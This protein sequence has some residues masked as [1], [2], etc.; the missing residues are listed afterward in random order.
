MKKV[1]ALLLFIGFVAV[2][3][4]AQRSLFYTSILKDP[5]LDYFDKVR[6]VDSIIASDTIYW[7]DSTLG[8]K[9]YVRWK[10]EMFPR[11]NGDGKLEDFTSSLQ[12][13]FDDQNPP[14]TVP[15]TL[16]PGA[17]SVALTASQ[18]WANWKTIG[19][20]EMVK[21][22]DENGNYTKQALGK[23]DRVW[24]YNTEIIYAASDKGGL[25]KTEDGG[26]TWKSVPITINKQGGGR[27]F[28]PVIGVRALLVHPNDPD[29]V[30]VST[31]YGENQGL[32]TFKTDDGGENW[33]L[34][35]LVD[36]SEDPAR[37]NMWKMVMDP[38]NPDHIYAITQNKLLE[39]TNGGGVLT[40]G[41]G[42]QVNTDWVEVPGSAGEFVDEVL[43][44]LEV[45]STGDVVYVAGKSI[46]EVD[47][48][49]GTVPVDL[50]SRAGTFMTTGATTHLFELPDFW[51]GGY[52]PNGCSFWDPFANY[53]HG[54][55]TTI[56]DVNDPNYNND[57]LRICDQVNQ[58]LATGVLLKK[59]MTREI[60]AEESNTVFPNHELYRR[61]KD[62]VEI[63]LMLKHLEVPP[64]TRLVVELT[65][66]T[67]GPNIKLFDSDFPSFTIDPT[68]FLVSYNGQKVWTLTA[69]YDRL[70]LKASANGSFNEFDILKLVEL[71]IFTSTLVELANEDW[72]GARIDIDQ[73]DNLYGWVHAGPT[74]TNSFIV[75][76]VGATGLS[77][78]D[79]INGSDGRVARG[80]HDAFEV[81]KSP[82]DGKG[83]ELYTGSVDLW[84]YRID[85]SDLNN[86][87]STYSA[88]YTNDGVLHVDYRDL[89]T[90]DL[91]DHVYVAHDGGL[92][93]INDNES[94]NGDPTFSFTDYSSITGKGL[95][96]GHFWSIDFER[97]GPLTF[98]GGG[99][100][101]QGAYYK[102]SSS[103]EWRN[104]TN[105]GGD[106]GDGG[107]LEIHNDWDGD[108][109]KESLI[110]FFP[111]GN[112]NAEIVFD[113]NNGYES[114]LGGPKLKQPTP[115]I[116]ST[117]HVIEQASDGQY[118]ACFSNVLYR[119][120]I[121]TSNWDIEKTFDNS[122]DA[123]VIQSIAIAPSD[124]DI[125]YV[126]IKE[127]RYGDALLGER[128]WRR[129]RQNGSL[130]WEAIPE[131]QFTGNPMGNQSVGDI[132]VSHLD[133]NKV[134]V[135]F[136][137]FHQDNNRVFYSDNAA[138][139]LSSVQFDDIVPGGQLPSFPASQ[140][141]TLPY[142]DDAVFVGTD[143]GLFIGCK[144]GSNWN[145]E[146][147]SK[148]EANLDWAIP[149]VHSNLPLGR[150]ADIYVDKDDNKVFA[151]VFG[152]GIWESHVP[153]SEPTADVYIGTTTWNGSI[154]QVNYD[155]IV[156]AGETF[157]LN[158]CQL[159]FG[160]ERRIIVENGGQLV[161]NNS[162]LTNA[163]AEEWGGILV[164]GPGNG[165]DQSNA[166]RVQISNST[167][168]NAEY[169]VR[170]GENANNS[171]GILIATTSTF[172]NC[173]Y[174]VYYN[175]YA[176]Q[177]MPITG[178]IVNCDF[179]CD[180]PIPGQG[181]LGVK[182]H[183]YLE[184]I[185]GLD[186]LSCS[187]HN[188]MEQ[189]NIA[190]SDKGI[191][192]EAWD[193][194]VNLK[195]S[196]VGSCSNLGD[197]NHFEGLKFGVRLHGNAPL[198][199]FVSNIMDA[200]FKNN[201]HG[202]DLFNQF[203]TILWNN[204]LEWDNEVVPLLSDQNTSCSGVVL[205]HTP[206][207]EFVDNL[208]N[209][210][211]DKFTFIGLKVNESTSLSQ[212][213]L[214]QNNLF[215]SEP[216]ILNNASFTPTDVIAQH[217]TGANDQ[218]YVNCN[219]YLNYLTDWLVDG[220]IALQEG[221]PGLGVDPSN[222]FG[223][224]CSNGI[225]PSGLTFNSINVSP[226]LVGGVDY[227]L[228]P[229]MVPSMCTQGLVN[230]LPSAGAYMGC[231]N[232]VYSIEDI[233][234]PGEPSGGGGGEGQSLPEKSLNIQELPDNAKPDLMVYPNP[235]AGL[236]V[237]SL[238][239]VAGITKINVV[240]LT[241][242]LV[243]TKE[244]NKDLFLHSVNLSQLTNGTY[245]VKVITE[246]QSYAKRIVIH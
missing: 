106:G 217:F 212:N 97:K 223:T 201:E 37:S 35:Y 62:G 202:I 140:V 84:K 22:L 20:E 102:E 18:E 132:A 101:H 122:N 116:P 145:W 38:T 42:S 216:S 182:A 82:Q 28:P 130:V 40:F 11:I 70:T 74:T 222:L 227:V 232:D 7:T 174:G 196:S 17:G 110:N 219:S 81:S 31:C 200:N 171:G 184:G 225:S 85:V 67:G 48:A 47:V 155:I 218:L 10:N 53:W 5:N 124:P 27:Y 50:K 148:Q 78:L 211:T 172:R 142:T 241:G 246:D 150:I 123:M 79:V 19:P 80:F 209:Y 43:Y 175:Q 72:H 61:L 244:V 105:T 193:A 163:C 57:W 89:F 192:I 86:S 158:D 99:I 215:S 204:V 226:T 228:D 51:T 44:D 180:G 52:N 13:N 135:T 240:D 56:T 66:S 8:A 141:A 198:A 126:A 230:F 115:G 207:F 93:R 160:R 220:Q 3:C 104:L 65:S 235:S 71:D 83:I 121:T 164:R 49:A 41:P 131:I 94:F 16:P 199:D 177:T 36:P 108:N 153:C 205:D 92:A 162:T 12:S 68:D 112:S 4:Q 129:T 191:G 233:Y 187:F 98:M 138:G 237:V 69:D 221:E 169:A 168:Q 194:S 39:T 137:H 183:I 179:Y 119:W 151:S 144:S 188:Y 111:G 60:Y 88:K 170:V 152:R 213:S 127:A 206:G 1:T 147:Y 185:R 87:N 6:M 189:D 32:G 195:R 29:I 238:D 139:P 229:F 46:W 186:V 23:M 176:Y 24:P 103:N 59:N 203:G 157:T 167:I 55:H 118:Y 25:F 128:F 156:G 9:Y 45:K 239:G 208:I 133:P 2:T 154:K 107:D 117:K 14:L 90:L 190:N 54:Q 34:Q 242:K 224:P 109:V 114:T 95:T 100:M 91:D 113:N 136:L 197:R 146:R 210:Q 236:F 30:Y 33:T 214:V 143:Y 21:N 234:C 159:A 96:I 231:I 181:G 58:R 75:R 161:I 15:Y 243:Y 165:I 64:N 26:N 149:G 73:Y 173:L 178:S 134:W 76:G 63:S 245:Y 77:T 166:G 125:M 120:N